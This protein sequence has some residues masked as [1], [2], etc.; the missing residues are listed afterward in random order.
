M[1]RQQRI[2]AVDPRKCVKGVRDKG[3]M[4]WANTSSKPPPFPKPKGYKMQKTKSMDLMIDVFGS[5]DFKSLWR[6]SVHEPNFS[7]K[8]DYMF[9]DYTKNVKPRNDVK[10]LTKKGTTL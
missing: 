1:L 9:L 5:G 2:T 6:K 3:H 10:N 4:K 8:D 7:K